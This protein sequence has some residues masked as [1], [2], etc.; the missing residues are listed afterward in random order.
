[1]NNLELET[2]KFIR[3]LKDKIEFLDSRSLNKI[4]AGMIEITREAFLEKAISNFGEMAFSRYS[5]RDYSESRVELSTIENALKIAAKT[6]S[7][8][9]RQGW[10]T[11]IVSDSQLIDNILSIQGELNGQG[12]NIT[13]LL[14]ICSDNNNFTN[15][16]E[17]NQGFVD[18]GMYSMSLIYA[19]TSLGIATCPLN[20]N[21]SIRNDKIIKKILSI[22]AN[23]NIIMFISV[24]HYL[25]VNKVP[26]SNRYELNERTI[27]FMGENY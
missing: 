4:N 20:A 22:G 24:G 9:N 19:L 16:T 15:Y 25:E 5:I 12:E 1:M 6:P 27:F 17:R 23:L 10:Q 3:I 18:G 21:L 8:C 14:V 11:Y 13:H 26:V 7:V 2:T